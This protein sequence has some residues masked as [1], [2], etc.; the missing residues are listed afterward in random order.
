MATVAYTSVWRTSGLSLN[1]FWELTHPICLFLT[2]VSQT[3]NQE[4]SFRLRAALFLEGTCT[5]VQQ[6]GDSI[7]CRARSCPQT[8]GVDWALRWYRSSSTVSWLRFKKQVDVGK[9]GKLTQA[10][11]WG[12]KSFYSAS[13]SHQCW[14]MRGVDVRS[15]GRGTPWL[16]LYSNHKTCFRRV[17]VILAFWISDSNLRVKIMRIMCGWTDARMLS[18]PV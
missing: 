16:S 12:V 5:Q 8:R 11:Q 1:L 10:T 14:A 13:A 4:T 7:V 15:L 2:S 18:V 17:C 6:L 3:R 9:R